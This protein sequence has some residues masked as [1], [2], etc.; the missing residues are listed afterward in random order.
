MSAVP[1]NRSLRANGR[2]RRRAAAILVCLLLFGAHARA[3]AQS[4]PPA[5]GQQPEDVLRINAELVQT[6]VVVLDR[7]GR[8]V[9]GLTA[10]DFQLSVAGRPAP[11][12]FLERV[13]AGGPN[14]EAQLARARGEAQ[15]AGAARTAL[16]PPDRGRLIFFFVDDFHLSAGSAKQARDTLQRFVETELG[17]NDLMCVLSASGQVGFLQQL[18]DERA[19]LR[20]AIAR[21]KPGPPPAA[22]YERPPMNE[23]QALAIAARDIDVTQFFV[24][25]VQEQEGIDQKG[26]FKLPVEVARDIVQGRAAALLQQTTSATT[27][28]LY[29]LESTIRPTAELP[30]RKLFF[31]LSDGFYLN[32]TD[33]SMLGLVRRVANAAARAGAVIY[34]IDTRGLSTGL[35]EAADDAAV[36]PSGRLVRAGLGSLSAAQDPLNA[37][38]RDTGG[39]AFLNSNALGAG[40]TDALR[41]TTRY[42]LL[43]WQPDE[44]AARGREGRVVVS[45]RGHPE[46]TVLA[47]RGYFRLEADTIPKVLSVRRPE[48]S[49]AGAAPAPAPAD[50]TLVSAIVAPYPSGA[51]PTALSLNYRDAPGYGPVVTAAVQ[52]DGAGIA[53]DPGAGDAAAVVEVAGVVFNSDGRQVASFKNRLNL[54]APAGGRPDAWRGVVSEYNVQLAPGLYQVRAAAHDVRTGRLGSAM[55]W[56]E[57]PDLSTGRLALASL[58]LSERTQGSAPTPDGAPLVRPIIDGRLRSSSGLRFRT[59]VYNAARGGARQLPD[60]ALQVQVFRDDQPIITAPVRFV[61]APSSADPA[62]LPY[63]AELALE[64]LPPGRYQLRVTALDRVGKASV[65]RRVNFEVR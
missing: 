20:A 61:A 44:A 57:V 8:F 39:R 63:E 26:E 25:K 10:N 9:D 64:R 48:S 52:V 27:R 40:V 65:P 56:I 33:T 37:L 59:Y 22:S 46:Y 15:A 6:D 43:A 62:R 19:V 50:A 38:A 36:D 30:G 54:T 14:E 2:A 41:E 7:Q 49:G 42:Y 53:F 45:V 13:T 12:A 16:R 5:P 35:A 55:R 24:R 11:V 18:T 60:V 28:T 51:L 29:A 34:S 32:H 47:R 31:F 58:Q 21:L 1:C 3:Q 4:Q 23:Y 17:Q